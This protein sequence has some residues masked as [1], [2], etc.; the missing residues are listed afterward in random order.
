M[1][2]GPSNPGLFI[3]VRGPFVFCG[4]AR[5]SL[6]RRLVEL[7]VVELGVV[8]AASE[9]L[10]VRALL[11]DVAVAHGRYLGVCGRELLVHCFPRLPELPKKGNSGS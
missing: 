8:A 1:R 7:G 4:L 5:F 2:E 9:Q 10:C 3:R 11:H 6:L